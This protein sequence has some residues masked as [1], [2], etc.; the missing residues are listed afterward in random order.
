[1]RALIL[2]SGMGKRMGSL[3]SGRPKCMIEIARGETI[4]SRQLRMLH[5][6]QI[7]DI[8]M[9][10]GYMNDMLEKY[11]L[12]LGIDQNYTFVFNEHYNQTNYIYSVYLAHH[13][14]HDDILMLHGDLVFEDSVLEDLLTHKGSCMTISSML[15]LSPKDFKAVVDKG[16]IR[17]VGVEINDRSYAA[18]PLYK[19]EWADWSK[20][21]DRIVVYCE[22]GQVTVYAEDALNDVANQCSIKPLDFCNRLCTEIDNFADLEEVRKH[23]MQIS[24]RR[25]SN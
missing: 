14:L 16:F 21:L 5:K 9:T 22:K 3:T 8:V 4:L 11:C 13:Y 24:Q 19:L 6:A 18:Q 23:I 15:P 17:E 20:W 7:S 1:M 2:N 25:E 12:G 10:T